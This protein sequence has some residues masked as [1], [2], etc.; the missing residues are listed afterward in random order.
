MFSSMLEVF[1]KKSVGQHN[2]K[3]NSKQDTVEIAQKNVKILLNKI[4]QE[5]ENYSVENISSGDSEVFS[6]SMCLEKSIKC[7][8]LDNC[9]NASIAKNQ[10]SVEDIKKNK[11]YNEIESLHCLFTW[12]LKSEKDIVANIKNKYNDNILD[13]SLSEFTFVR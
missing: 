9:K 5:S 7:N 2:D 12:Q 1:K 6:S 4:N 11:L 8:F 10:T 3:G 13:L